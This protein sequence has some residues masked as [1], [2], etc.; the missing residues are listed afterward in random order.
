MKYN[1]DIFARGTFYIEP[2]FSYKVFITRI[3]IKNLNSFYTNFFFFYIKKKK[4]K[5]NNKIKF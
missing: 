1:E 2:K 5:K 4:K 3:Y